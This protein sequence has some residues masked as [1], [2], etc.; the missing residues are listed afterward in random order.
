MCSWY[1]WGDMSF[2]SAGLNLGRQGDLAEVASQRGLRLAP[3]DRLLRTLVVVLSGKPQGWGSGFSRCSSLS[4]RGE[5]VPPKDSWV[6]LF[7]FL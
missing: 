3:S 6:E 4:E 1:L 2:I 5:Q 7:S